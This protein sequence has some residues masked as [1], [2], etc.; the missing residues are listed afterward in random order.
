MKSIDRLSWILKSKFHEWE[1]LSQLNLKKM[2][3]ILSLFKQFILNILLYLYN[4]TA[5]L[6]F[7]AK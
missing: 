6:K 5:T 7:E 4:K 2:Q 3:I 1:K